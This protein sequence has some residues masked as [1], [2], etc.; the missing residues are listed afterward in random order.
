M[1]AFKII[2]EVTVLYVVCLDLVA[3][4]VILMGLD[5]VWGTSVVVLAICVKLTIMEATV[6]HF[7]Y[8]LTTPRGAIV[9]ETWLKRVS[10]SLRGMVAY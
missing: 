8:H 6:I 10:L 9:M 4:Y 2:T 5:C 1:D 7:V 3:T